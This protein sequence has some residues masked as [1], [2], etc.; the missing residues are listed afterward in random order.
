[1]S[2]PVREKETPEQSIE[3][4]QDCLTNNIGNIEQPDL[5]KLVLQQKKTPLFRPW[6]QKIT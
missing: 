2:V 4:Q 6:Q 5:L 3:Y 1:M